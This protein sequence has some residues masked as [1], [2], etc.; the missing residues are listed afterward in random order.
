MSGWTP[1]N[2]PT[3]AS[4]AGVRPAVDDDHM[5]VESDGYED[6]ADA[7]SD[8]ESFSDGYEDGANPDTKV[9]RFSDWY[10]ERANADADV[11]SLDHQLSQE[12]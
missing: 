1:I 5:D 6:Y 2:S 4:Q 10:E 11:E 3:G 8:V 12:S 7:D 9:Q